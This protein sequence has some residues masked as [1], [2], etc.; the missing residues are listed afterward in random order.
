MISINEFSALQTLLDKHTFSVKSENQNNSRRGFPRHTAETFGMVKPRFKGGCTLSRASI[1]YPDIFD[2][3]VRIGKK[4]VP[5]DFTSIQ[6]NKNVVC[7]KHTDGKNVGISCII[8]FGEYSGCDLIVDGNPVITKYTPYIFN[9]SVKPH[10]NTNDLI[11]TKYSIVFYIHSSIIKHSMPYRIAIP[12]L[13]RANICN[14]RTLHTLHRMGIPP[15]FINIFCV[16]TEYDEYKSTLNP[17]L[18]SCLVVGKRGLNAQLKYIHSSYDDA[19]KIIIMD[20]DIIDICGVSNLDVFFKNA[21]QDCITYGSNLWG[22][23]PVNNPFF[24]EKQAAISTGLKFIIGQ[25]YGFVN[26]DFIPCVCE[27]KNDVER[28]LRFYLRD[29]ALLR[30]N[31]ISIKTKN[32]NKGGLGTLQN[33]IDTIREEA[34]YLCREFPHTRLKIRKNGIYEVVLI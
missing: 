22:V 28:S 7:P 14:N 3:L 34:L 30:Y 11:G 24:Y 20:D 29:G 16:D 26:R 27:N 32:Y 13:S 1:I 31:H 15:D 10:W 19:D 5:F 18:Y 25:M 12:S 33:R 21:F 9:G 2:E 4:Y 17:S 6:V 23:Y 8:S